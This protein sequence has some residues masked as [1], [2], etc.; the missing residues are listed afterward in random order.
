MADV[1]LP[2]IR[3]AI[4][5]NG[6]DRFRNLKVAAVISELAIA[7]FAK[8]PTRLGHFEFKTLRSPTVVRLV[9]TTVPQGKRN[10]REF[11]DTLRLRRRLYHSA[12]YRRLR[13]NEKSRF[14]RLRIHSCVPRRE[15]E[16]KTLRSPVSYRSAFGIDGSPAR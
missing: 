14:R 6:L 9:S 3:S 2:N 4:N 7:L 11:C 8:L 16:F 5:V 10:P 13:E 15:F 12:F 1:I